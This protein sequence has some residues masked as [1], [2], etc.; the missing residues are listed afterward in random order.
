MLGNK[1]IKHRAAQQGATVSGNKY[2]LV[3]SHGKKQEKY[4]IDQFSKV[5]NESYVFKFDLQVYK[6]KSIIVK[7]DAS[8]RFYAGKKVSIRKGREKQAVKYSKK[9]RF[10]MEDLYIYKNR[11]FFQL[12]RFRKLS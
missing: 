3:V 2:Y 7:S 5:W 8:Y 6:N 12:R 10:E 4:K 1:K 9:R 11:V